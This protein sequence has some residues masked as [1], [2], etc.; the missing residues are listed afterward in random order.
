MADGNHSAQADRYETIKVE[1]A[2]RVGLVHLHRPKNLN[3]LNAQLSHGLLDALRS[4]D[5]NEAIGAMIVT[6][7]ERALRHHHRRRERSI[8]SARDQARH[9]ARH[10]RITAPHS[11][12]RK[13]A[14]DGVDPDGA[15]DASGR[16]QGGRHVR[17]DRAAGQP[18]AGGTASRQYDR[19]VQ[20][21]RCPF[22]E[23]GGEPCFRKQPGGGRPDERRL[24]QAAFATEGQCE[25]MN[26]FLEK[27]SPIFPQR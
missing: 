11:S 27:R 23:R 7:S 15:D 4:F 22:C 18:H 21:D 3:A 1:T 13:V 10:R 8:R 16:S 17:L 6:G 2:G 20:L 5:E 12:R 25:G 14:C 26:A 24:F 19:G 9:P